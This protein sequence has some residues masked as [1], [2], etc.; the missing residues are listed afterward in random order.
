MENTVSKE[1]SNLRSGQLPLS[2]MM[3]LG[4]NQQGPPQELLFSELLRLHSTQED[5]HNCIPEDSLSVS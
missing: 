5:A 4:A 1:T 3:V 2:F